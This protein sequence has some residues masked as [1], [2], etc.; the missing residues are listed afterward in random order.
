M[1]GF[2][3][4]LIFILIPLLRGLNNSKKQKQ[5]YQQK[6]RNVQTFPTQ[7]NKSLPSSPWKSIIDELNS[8]IQKEMFGQEEMVEKKVKHQMDQGIDGYYKEEVYPE[9]N[10]YTNSEFGQEFQA[11][12]A[13]VKQEKIINNFKEDLTKNIPKK[14]HKESNSL[15][16]SKNHLVQGIIF[17]EI[18]GPPKSKR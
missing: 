5:E 7:N 6:R 16:F 4:L 2:L 12:P 15:E 14:K 10:L 3:P 17:S 8:K 1:E 13:E 11:K 18:L 9:N